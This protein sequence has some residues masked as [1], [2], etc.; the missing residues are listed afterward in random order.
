[1]VSDRKG[2]TLIPTGS[3]IVFLNDVSIALMARSGV[4][5]K[6]TDRIFV[7]HEGIM[8]HDLYLG[9]KALVERKDVGLDLTKSDLCPSFVE[10]LTA[11]GMGLRVA[12]SHTGNYREDDFTSLETI[13]RFLEMDLRSFMMERIDGEFNILLEGCLNDEDISPSA[14]SVN[15][16]ALAI[17]A[18]PI[19]AV[20]LL[21]FTK[22]IGDSDDAP[23]EKDE[24][25]IIFRSV[26]NNRI[27]RCVLPPKL[28]E[29]ENK[30]LSLTRRDLVK[31]PKR[32]HLKQVKLLPILLFLSMRIAT[33]ISMEISLEKLCDIH[34]KE[35]TRHT[36]LDNM[37]NSRTHKLMS[38]LSKDRDSYDVNREREVEKDKAYAELER[39][40][41]EAL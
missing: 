15:N 27:P 20:P 24:V 40:C 32:C 1:M 39:K 17:N 28:M 26:T 41:N 4:I 6:S 37:L 29:R 30:L 5:S 11:K 7:F 33:M 19:T 36:V 31:K 16:E 13:R 14:K 18:E 8:Y 12:D 22:N 23:S 34:N 38:M 35:Y 21:R 10:D 2:T 9:K 3:S 25:A